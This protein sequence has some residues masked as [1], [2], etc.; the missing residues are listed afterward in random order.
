MLI[1]AE[2]NSKELEF[3]HKEK[4]KDNCRHFHDKK[5]KITLKNKLIIPEKS[6]EKYQTPGRKTNTIK[7]LMNVG[8]PG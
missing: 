3:H 2:E 4:C 1:K 6:S 5:N 8:A 7:K